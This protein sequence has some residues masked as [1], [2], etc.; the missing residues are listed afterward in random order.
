MPFCQ[1]C[2]RPLNEGEVCHC[3]EAQQS[4][5]M[6]QPYPQ[7]GQPQPQQSPYMNQPY[8]QQGVP[9]PQGQ[10]PYSY[11][12]Q[13]GQQP[14]KENKTAVGCVIAFAI[15][16]ATLPVIGILAAILVPSMIGYVAKSKTASANSAAKSCYRAIQTSLVDLDNENE[17]KEGVYII[18][19][20]PGKHDLN[21][22]YNT[23]KLH[24]AIHKYFS[25]VENITFFAVIEGADVTYIAVYSDKDPK[26]IGTYPK[27]SQM[28][29]AVDYNGSY[30]SG[31]EDLETLYEIAC[32]EVLPS[33]QIGEDA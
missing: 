21:A 14:P 13:Q 6:N 15:C 4:P 29:E 26:Y 1:N 30:H 2:G 23:E 33:G 3:Q 28:R 9:Y 17:L 8:P 20:M 31:E 19:N 12:Y 7:Q 10:Q 22:P 11:Q 25:D 27:A 18:T 16:A 24:S 32:D 5:Y